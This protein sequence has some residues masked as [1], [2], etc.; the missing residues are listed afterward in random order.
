MEIFAVWKYICVVV[1]VIAFK[2]AERQTGAFN[3]GIAD[4]VGTATL[5]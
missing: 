3:L 2:M 4:A 5:Q 1:I